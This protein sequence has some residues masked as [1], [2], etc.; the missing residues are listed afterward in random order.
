MVENWDVII[1]GAGTAGIPAAIFAGQR[2][3]KV[4]LIDAADKIGGTLHLTTGQMS[5]AGTSLQKKL[6]INDNS[7]DHFDD[8]MRISE[9][10]ADKDLVRLAVDNAAETFDWLMTN[11]FTPLDNHPVLG[12]AHEPYSERR[13]YWGPFGGISILDAITPLL[14]EQIASGNVVVSLRT[15][16]KNI[17]LNKMEVIGIEIEAEDGTNAIINGKNIILSTGGYSSNPKLFKELSGPTLYWKGAY[18]FSNGEGLTIAN[19]IGGILRG[20]QNYLCGYGA[21]LKNF[22]YPSEVTTRIISHPH[23]RLPWEIHVNVNGKR[24]FQEDYD[25]V[26][27]REKKLLEQDKLKAW[28]VFDD[29]ILKKSP[30]LLKDFSKEDTIS[31]FSSHPMF[32]YANDLQSLANKSGVNSDGLIKTI[33]EYNLAIENNQ[34]DPFGRMH[35]P[36][37]IKKPP[38]YSICTHGVSITSTVGIS[39][40]SEL[41]ILN[42]KKEPIKNLFAAGE[43]LGSGQTMG[44]CSAGGMMLTPA[45]TF[46]RLLG[47]KFLS[48]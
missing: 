8:V 46:G 47:Q 42:E 6:G 28:V 44:K 43:I 30:P 33:E 37:K 9:N 17:I 40:N 5:A 45:L 19:K 36:L 22:D 32:N 20:K 34:T 18:P 7:N 31:F 15:K 29:E 41:K 39:V 2:G 10:T 13:Y 4:L 27:V 35:R 24:F 12:N 11:G 25:S 1:V 48:W 23:L 3:A 14:D 16:L 21:I 26:H 38:F